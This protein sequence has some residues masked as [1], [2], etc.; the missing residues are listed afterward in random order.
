MRFSL[1]APIPAWVQFFLIGTLL[2][3][4]MSSSA[5]SICLG[6]SVGT[7]LFT[8]NFRTDLI[9]LFST[10]WCKGA[11]FLFCSALIGCLWSPAD[12]SQQLIVIE[13]Y[14]KLLYLPILVVGFQN[15]TTRQLSLY[16]FL[17]AM[18]ITCCLSILKFHGYLPFFSFAPDNVFRNHIMTGFMV[19]FAAYLS[20][21]FCFR[22]QRYA[23]IAYGFLALIFTYQVLFVSG[24]R[25]GYIIY[26][27]C[28]C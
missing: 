16:A 15:R 17:A 26:Y 23:R 12:F 1:K 8:P 10:N 7:I 28:S 20:F 19:A 4:P 6:L 13:K 2:F 9:S 14:S 24:S 5:K 22:Q 3:F 21:L 11:I 18:L 27:S 25:T